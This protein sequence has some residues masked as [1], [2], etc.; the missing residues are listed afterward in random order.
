MSHETERKD[1]LNIAEDTVQKTVRQLRIERNLTQ[2][3]LA[4]MAGIGH[5]V[6]ARIDT[7]TVYECDSHRYK[8]IDSRTAAAVASALGVAVT[9][10]QWLL[11]L[12]DAATGTGPGVK[13]GSQKEPIAPRFCTNAWCGMQLPAD[14]AVGCDNCD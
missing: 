6:M 14:P 2:A 8:C 11:P 12:N 1:T 3:R 10:I 5:A 7:G 13:H 4:E 9:D